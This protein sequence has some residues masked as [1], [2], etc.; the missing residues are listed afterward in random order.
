MRRGELFVNYLLR[1]EKFFYLKKSQRDI[2]IRVFDEFVEGFDDDD[3][4]VIMDRSVYIIR[5]IC[6]YF[7][8]SSRV[9]F[10][11]TRISHIIFIRQLIFYFIKYFRPDISMKSIAAICKG[12]S[13]PDDV[14]FNRGSVNNSIKIIENYMATDRDKL[15][16]VLEFT[17]IFNNRFSDDS[18]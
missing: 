11:R 15:A 3:L 7:G 17:R 8:V 18:K 14:W 10:S 16:L 4:D 13:D 6:K 2:I 9:V 12:F 5:F 1:K